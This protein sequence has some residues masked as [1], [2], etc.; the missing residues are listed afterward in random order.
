MKKYLVFAGIFCASFLVF[1]AAAGMIWT[2]FYTPDISAAWQ[3]TGALSSET[4]LVK[5]SAVSPFIIAVASLAVTF[6][7]TR[8]LGKRIVV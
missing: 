6:G 1:Q 3:Q 4:M 2:L 8:L 5:A 7:L